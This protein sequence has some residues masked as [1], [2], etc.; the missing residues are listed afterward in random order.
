MFSSAVKVK[1]Y[2]RLL[3][4]H[5]TTPGSF[6]NDAIGLDLRVQRKLFKSLHRGRL[7]VREKQFI[8]LCEMKSAPRRELIQKYA[9]QT[10]SSAHLRKP[11]RKRLQSSEKPIRS[12]AI[13]TSLTPRNFSNSKLQLVDNKGFELTLRKFSFWRILTKIVDFFV[14]FDFSKKIISKCS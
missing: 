10:W 2:R 7:E 13:A 14:L 11:N 9:L 5:E 3:K 4:I 6:R 12:N 1:N 8:Y